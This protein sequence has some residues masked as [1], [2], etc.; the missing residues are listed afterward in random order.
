[1]LNRLQDQKNHVSSFLVKE[2]KRRLRRLQLCVKQAWRPQNVGYTI[3]CKKHT[4]G[5]NQMVTK[6]YKI[7]K[8]K[9]VKY[10]NES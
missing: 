3:T 5:K 9:M 7:P 1:M 2:P 10:V 8:I 4:T 6:L